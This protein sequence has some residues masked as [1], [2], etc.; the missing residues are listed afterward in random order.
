MAIKGYRNKFVTGEVTDSGIST[1]VTPD[2]ARSMYADG[3]LN[4]RTPDIS[5]NTVSDFY[6]ALMKL[7]MKRF[8]T[9]MLS[10]VFFLNIF[11]AAIYFL[12]GAEN[13][14][15]LNGNS[16]SEQLL[17]VLL[18][19]V[20][21]MTTAGFG[22]SSVSYY[23]TFAGA[24]EALTGLLVVAISTGLIY[25]RFSQAAAKVV[26]SN[27][28]L[29]SPYKN[30]RALTFRIANARKNQLVN[31]D[32]T[33]QMA[34]NQQTGEKEIRRFL[35]LD[36]ESKHATFFPLSWT[37]VH[38]INENSPILNFTE[39]DFKDGNIELIVIINGFDETF[40]QTVH[41]RF[42]YYYKDLV[43]GAKFDINFK[44]QADGAIEHYLKKLNDYH[45]EEL[46]A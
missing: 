43:W 27:N 36:L 10:F 42:G 35:N 23:T 44:H 40:N 18:F 20:Q 29:M 13:I 3:S 37:I 33:V 11:F 12:I 9:L 39:K 15:G 45:A 24:I 2:N 19:S 25:G 41:T 28:M 26:H 46:P 8:A 16:L 31:V 7:P 1:V 4:I 22:L 6:I 17:K 5:A 21:S 14:I 38:P 34:F 30:G 32:W